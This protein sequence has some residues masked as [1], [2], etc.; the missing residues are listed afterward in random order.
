MWLK[1]YVENAIKNVF[2]RH[3]TI[4]C[5]MVSNWSLIVGEQLKHKAI[6]VG[7][8]FSKNKS[9]DA[10]L[11]LEV[12]NPCCGLEVQMMTTTIL[13]KIAVYFGY[14]A[15]SKIKITIANTKPCNEILD[16][17]AKSVQKKTL[18][19]AEM[20]DVMNVINRNKND[21]IRKILINIAKELEC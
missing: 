9:N 8:K 17:N 1:G 21:E 7:V 14:K 13:D 5:K 2:E 19:L 6:P 11:L 16:K 3:G 12:V 20:Q 10:T 15:V 18:S 4:Y